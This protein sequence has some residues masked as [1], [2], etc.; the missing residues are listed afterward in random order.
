MALV[1]ALTSSSVRSSAVRLY[2]TLVVLNELYR[3]ESLTTRFINDLSVVAT[4][5][6]TCGLSSESPAM[7]SCSLSAESSHPRSSPPRPF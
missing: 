2:S 5:L 6:A 1:K 3:F 7:H 4:C